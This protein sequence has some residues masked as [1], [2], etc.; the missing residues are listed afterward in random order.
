[1]SE[2]PADRRAHVD[3][4]L[5]LTILPY[6]GLAVD[7]GCGRGD[8]LCL[9]A[10]RYQAPEARFIGVDHSAA[11]SSL[12]DLQDPRVTFRSA[13][14]DEALPFDDASVDLVYSHN[15]V[16]CLPDPGHFAVEVGR[17]LRPGGQAVIAH[18]DWDTQVYDG[19]VKAGIRRLVASFADWQQ[20]WMAHA[21]G[22]MG[23][24]LSGIFA[25][26]KRLEGRVHTRVLTNTEFAEPWFGHANALAMRGPVKRGLA[27]AVDYAQFLEDQ[28]A[29][30]DQG[31][32]FY[33]I[34][35]FAYVGYRNAI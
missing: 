12:E 35:G 18:W 26:T 30:N 9:L 17:V 23:R 32:Y 13:A 8:D 10:A 14:L 11:A 5:D 31:R 29:L 4:L 28:A 6:G 7:L 1:M 24:R 3:W 15:L 19:S 21:D 2:L 22:W 33:G 25:G 16:E 34:T 20:A 27:S